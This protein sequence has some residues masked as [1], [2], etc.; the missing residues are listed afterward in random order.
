MLR[1]IL[2][3]LGEIITENV[4]LSAKGSLSYYRLKE[5]KTWFVRKM[6]KIIRLKENR[7]SW[8]GYRIQAK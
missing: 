2:I 4:K 7:L 6:V 5:H 8:S 1:W 3:V